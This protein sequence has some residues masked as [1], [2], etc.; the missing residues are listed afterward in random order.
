[1]EVCREKF[2]CPFLREGKIYLCALPALSHHYNDYFGKNMPADGS[3][4]IHDQQLTGEAILKQLNTPAAICRYCTCDG[5]QVY[6]WDVSDK[7][8]R[9]W[10]AN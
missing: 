1:M 7:N 10:S 5:T 2:Y 3:I 4:A 9:E 6:P 8:E